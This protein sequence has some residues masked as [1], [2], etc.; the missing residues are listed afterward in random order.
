MKK[1]I[2]RTAAL[3]MTVVSTVGLLA[4][5]NTKTTQDAGASKEITKPESFK[6]M[7][8]GTVFTESNG[9][10]AFYDKIAELT[11]L[12]ITWVRPDHSS[13]YDAV[14]N[15]FNSDE[16]MPDVVLLSSD[17]Y[18]LYAQSGFLWNMTEAWENSDT[19]N[20]G[21]LIDTAESV[22]SSMMVNGEDGKQGMYGMA[23][24]R[25][26]GCCT[27]VKKKWLTDCGIS[28]DVFENNTMDFNTYYGYLKQMSEKKGHY[29]ISCPGFVSAEAPYT[30]YLPEFYQDAS[31]TFYKNSSGQYVDGFSEKSM[32]DALKRISTAI[33][34]GVI[35]KEA[36][37]NS[38]SNARD[39][40][41]STDPSNESGVFTYWAGTWANTL[42][43]NLA[44]KGLD[45][46]L[47]AIK[48]VKELGAYVER[49]PAS[50]C[51]TTAA[52]NP[53][54]IYK[55]FI[56]SMLDGGD[57]QLTWLFGAKG[58]HWN[59]VAEAVTV[60]GKE[61]QPSTYKDGEF[62]FLPS[63]E[64]PNTLTQKDTLLSL[65]SLTNGDPAASQTPEVAKSNN[66]FF[67]ENSHVAT[68]LPMTVELSEG[69]GDVNTARQ[70]VVA[71]VA[72]G[73]MSVEDGM[74]YYTKTVGSI[75]ED[76]LK[77]LNK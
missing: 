51:I 52:K 55:Y 36:V 2:K 38:T 44:N 25:G 57:V 4:C 43:V 8:D 73:Y 14:A 1:I 39:K 56:D 58:T 18:A 65:G 3:S 42:K 30:N 26:N 35:D 50:W 63:P 72:L 6:V 5:G 29:V 31:Y 24:Y 48:P 9:G 62:H 66:A 77:S 34:D 27:Y 21:R 13:Y 33:A 7:C 71:Q 60:Q 22:L 41:Y 11:G 64:K 28:T 68:P 59:D 15:A 69:V 53:E 49:I 74:S 37:N 75:V 23:T 45:D 46:E 54:G 19:K 40:F 32:Q 16:S 70:Y 10:Q 20:S 47:I 12:D 76:I 67:A 61:D 17:Y